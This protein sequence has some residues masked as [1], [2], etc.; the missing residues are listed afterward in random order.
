MYAIH[1]HTQTNLSFTIHTQARYIH[2]SR[3]NNPNK[4]ISPN[5]YKSNHNQH[6]RS[7]RK[8]RS[9][10]YQHGHGPP[11]NMPYPPYYPYPPP[12]PHG[13]PPSQSQQ[14]YYY[15]PPPY[16]YPYP[17]PIGTVPAS[18]DVNP[19]QSF[20]PQSSRSASPGYSKTKQNKRGH[21]DDS[22]QQSRYAY[23]ALD[24]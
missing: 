24:I 19:T 7:R 10:G 6:H 12:G 4:L 11:P 20:T 3:S 18:G 2:G 16:P 8:K 14:P 9:P 17:Y 13:P 22:P 5:T 23:F 1:H 15:Y 21:V